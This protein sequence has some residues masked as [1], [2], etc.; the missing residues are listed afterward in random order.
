MKLV[1]EIISYILIT[2]LVI[3][4]IAFILSWGLPYLQKKQDEMK[5]NLIFNSLFG[6]ESATSIPSALKKILI[7][8]SSERIGGYDGVWNITGRSI[9]FS[10][11]SRVSP[12]NSEEWIT[13][14]GCVK[15]ACQFLLEPFYEVQARSERADGNFRV[16]YRVVLKNLIIDNINYTVIFENS[17][18]STS[19]YIHIIF[20]RIDEN[21]KI[22]YL[23]VL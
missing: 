11:V 20:S 18:Y 15:D 21:N 3:S 14:Y 12:V 5:I 22:V 19:K 10:F 6:E 9:T 13:I 8:K 4:L 16:F 23:R 1:S 7:T 17:L 2:L